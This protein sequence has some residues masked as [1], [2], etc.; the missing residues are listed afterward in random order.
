M[1]AGKRIK[2]GERKRGQGGEVT[3]GMNRRKGKKLKRKQSKD[4]RRQEASQLLQ[5]RPGGH[6]QRRSMKTA[7]TEGPQLPHGPAA[8]VPR[9]SFS[10]Q[11]N[12]Q[13]FLLPSTTKA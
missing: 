12:E 11:E 6:M 1:G 7:S 13:R 5:A 8:P 10:K 3:T 2:R 4:K 9:E